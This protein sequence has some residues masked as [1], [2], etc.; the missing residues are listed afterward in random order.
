[1]KTIKLLPAIIFSIVI[2]SFAISCE[3]QK[4]LDKDNSTNKKTDQVDT[5]EQPEPEVPEELRIEVQSSI[6]AALKYLST[7]IF[8][9]RTDQPDL[10]HTDF[11]LLGVEE[12]NIFVVRE[13]LEFSDYSYV[14]SKTSST[15]IKNRIKC[16][17][18]MDIVYMY[19]DGIIDNTTSALQT[20]MELTNEHTPG[21][22]YLLYFIYDFPSY[23]FCFESDLRDLMNKAGPEYKDM[24][25][26][27]KKAGMSGLID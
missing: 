22:K 24:R 15:E 13:P 9:G 1:M 4:N 18:R 19:R 3:Q 14:E 26:A 2:G 8:S 20:T 7:H 12:A 5:V 11:M 25:S 10:F 23:D 6:L 27:F 16:K 21:N 17:V